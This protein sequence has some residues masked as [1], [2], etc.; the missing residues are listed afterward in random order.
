MPI[1]D[2]SYRRYGGGKTTPGQAWTV[3]AWAGLRNMFRKRA[4]LGL[5]LFAWLPF[6]VR[7]VQIYIASN[8]PQA[9]ML[10]PD[11]KMFRD[12]LEQQDFFVFIITI[13]VGAGLIA[14]DRRANALQIYLSKP[15]L[16]SEY[17]A[18][19]AAIL[20]FFLMLVTWLPAILLL[21]LQVMFKGS[22][23]FMRANLFLFPAITVASLLQA[24]LATFTML[25]LSSL[26]KSSR[27]V[28]ILYAGI[29]F[30]TA[31][32]Y[33]AMYAITGSTKMA[34]LSLGANL[35]QVVD[36]IFRVPPRYSTPWSVSLIVLLG[37]I[38]L[39]ISVLE[40]RVRGVEVVT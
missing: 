13:Y 7:A 5:M 16:R 14:S 40:R 31:A 35:S 18:G 27:Y 10:A 32:I 1:H 37:L 12:F 20:F 6:V 24:L 36:V 15:L 33:G 2:Q 39:S 3:I 17:I 4:F 9:S 29:L 23:E 22:F 28:G 26:S 30:F 8:F 19:K 38:A 25:A 11:A 21:F 34:Y